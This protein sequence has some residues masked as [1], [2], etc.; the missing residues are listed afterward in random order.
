[1]SPYRYANRRPQSDGPEVWVRTVKDWHV[2]VRI[3][4]RKGKDSKEWRFFFYFC[5]EWCTPTTLLI[6]LSINILQIV[7]WTSFYF[8]VIYICSVIIT[9]TNSSS[10]DICLESQSLH[11]DPYNAF[12][13]KSVSGVIWHLKQL[14]T[15]PLYH[16]TGTS[17]GVRAVFSSYL[18]LL[19]LSPTTNITKI[20]NLWYYFR[21][22]LM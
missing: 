2:E 13:S 22:K 6:S 10:N 14:L 15:H 8:W 18:W 4:N 12:T 11:W 1:M 5:F 9:I 21:S 7:S 3:K 17:L 19:E 16:H 20:Y